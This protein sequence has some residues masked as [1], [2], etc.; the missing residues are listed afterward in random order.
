MKTLDS[1]QP[2][3]TVFVGNTPRLVRAVGRRNGKV[4]SLTF[5]IRNCSWTRRPYTVLVGSDLKYRNVRPTGWPRATFGLPSDQELQRNI[6]A[7]AADLTLDCCDV[8][9]WP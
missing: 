1:V 2:G 5:A 8:R 4:R 6:G 3:D 7:D 9:G